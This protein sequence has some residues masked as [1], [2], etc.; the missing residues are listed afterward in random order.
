MANIVDEGPPGELAERKQLGDW[1]VDGRAEFVNE[2]GEDGG[3]RSD[4]A[5]AV[6]WLVRPTVWGPFGW[7]ADALPSGIR[8]AGIMRFP[9]FCT[10]K[11]DNA[12]QHFPHLLLC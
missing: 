7:A 4:G 1:A 2:A 8:D 5:S 9:P 6:A 10:L 11:Q 3:A 12:P